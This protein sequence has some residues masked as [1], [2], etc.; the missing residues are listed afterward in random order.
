MLQNCVTAAQADVVFD[1]KNNVTAVIADVEAGTK[2][3]T[4]AIWRGY[5]CYDG[6]QKVEQDPQT[7]LVSGGKDLRERAQL[8]GSRTKE[9]DEH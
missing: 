7:T 8:I 1:F 5:T 9:A 4:L 3:A 2:T 6:R